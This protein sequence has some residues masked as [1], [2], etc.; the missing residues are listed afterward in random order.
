M[1]AEDPLIVAIMEYLVDTVPEGTRILSGLRFDVGV[2]PGV[3]Q[4]GLLLASLSGPGGEVY[5]W[6]GYSFWDEIEI[7]VSPT[8]VTHGRPR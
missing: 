3:G 6:E 7:R 4:S 8:W 1:S 2:I 5:S